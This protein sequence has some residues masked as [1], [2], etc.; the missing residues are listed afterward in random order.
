MNPNQNLNLKANLKTQLS[1]I[2]LEDNCGGVNFVSVDTK[3]SNNVSKAVKLRKTELVL[4]QQIQTLKQKY[5]VS[6]K[7]AESLSN[8]INNDFAQRYI[9][10]QTD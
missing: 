2:K 9:E 4:I 7:D 6:D 1:H 10:I 5:N 8:S 3:H